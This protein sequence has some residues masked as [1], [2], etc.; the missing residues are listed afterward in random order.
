MEKNEGVGLQRRVVGRND[1]VESVLRADQREL[2]SDA[3]RRACDD[4]ER[5]GGHGQSL[6]EIWL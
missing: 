1:E 4:G 3:G 2:A 5:T 6:L